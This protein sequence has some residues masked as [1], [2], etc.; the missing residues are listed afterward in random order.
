MS[1][2]NKINKN[3]VDY[4]LYDA[5]IGELDSAVEGQILGVNAQ[6]KL[7]PI[8]APATGVTSFNGRHADVMPASGDYTAEMVGAIPASSKGA[9]SGVAELDSDG[10]V[11]SSQ[12]PSYVD[13]VLE[14]AN[15]SAFPTT[16]ESGKIYIALDDNKTY[17]WGGSTYVVIGSSLALGETDATA[18]RGDRGKS[19]YDH[20]SAKGSAFASGLYKIT[21]N[22]E[23]HVT[24]ATAVVKSDITGLGIP[25][26]DTT[27]ND[28]TTSI[29]GLMAAADKTKLN[30]IATGATAVSESTVSGWGFTKNTGNA[31]AAKGTATRPVYISATDVATPCTYGF[32]IDSTGPYIESF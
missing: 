26:Q 13:D 17:R 8:D 3:S 4:D 19:A 10:K 1:Y 14:Y 23:G 9:N 22:S 25:A 16:G 29:H 24:A 15:R 7:V 5:R 30:G 18:Y 32:G 21:T 2:V 12:L 28:A 11:P 31:I 6:K 27:Y 20:A